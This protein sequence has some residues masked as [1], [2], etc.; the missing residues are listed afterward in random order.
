MYLPLANICKAYFLRRENYKQLFLTKHCL[1]VSFGHPNIL[2]KST[3]KSP[4][5]FHNF[6]GIF[7]E[8]ALDNSVEICR[9]DLFF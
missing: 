1:C 2:H 3:K 8:K 5:V 4:K 9:N 6:L 7:Y